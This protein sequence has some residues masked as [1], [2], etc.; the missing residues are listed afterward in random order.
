MAVNVRQLPDDG[1]K[2]THTRAKLQ[3]LINSGAITKRARDKFAA[4]ASL[5]AVVKY[6]PEP[7]VLQF[8]DQE[9]ITPVLTKAGQQW[10][11]AHGGL[12]FSNSPG[13]APITP[14]P[15]E[16]PVAK[17][18]RYDKPPVYVGSP[19]ATEPE[20]V[21]RAPEEPQDERARKLEALRALVQKV[22]AERVHEDQQTLKTLVAKVSE[23]AA[24]ATVESL[25]R[26]LEATIME[27]VNEALNAALAVLNEA[28]PVE[29]V[30][31]HPSG[32]VTKVTGEVHPAFQRVLKLAMR[33]KSIALIGPTGCGKT[34]L[35]WQVATALKL[36]FATIS[37]TMGQSESKLVGGLMPIGEGGKWEVFIT[38]FVECFRDGGVFLFDEFDSADPNVLL[39]VNQALANGRIDLP[40][41]GTVTRHADFVAMAALNTFGTG[42]DRMYV[43][44]TQLDE[45]S[46]DRFRIGQ[47]EMDYDRKLE[48]KLCGPQHKA[49]LTKAWQVR[50]AIAQHRL[51]RNM[52]TR[53]ILDGR[54][55]LEEG[56]SVAEVLSAFVSGWS[57]EE[58]AKVGIKPVA[59]F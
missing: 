49:W 38:Q 57:A 19:Q 32:E 2:S 53:F 24:G 30:V 7:E 41:I 56:D 22:V 39:I 20:P 36:R 35:A 4:R 14:T 8:C 37:C 33:R 25:G 58:M 13:G 27:Q 17:D 15:K 59:L 43:G 18:S 54:D 47:V 28:R 10:V 50:D 9:G 3:Q 26:A 46:L 16:A 52:S 29:L 45:A 1:W 5:R 42:A 55:M 48:A 31:K 11:A 23:A 12:T 51:R 21:Q 40:V 34:H 44:R 6:W